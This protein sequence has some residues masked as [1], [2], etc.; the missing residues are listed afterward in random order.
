M[1]TNS[2]YKQIILRYSLHESDKLYYDK[3]NE[4]K[5]NDGFIVK[6]VDIF[7]NPSTFKIEMIDDFPLEC[8]IEYIERTHI[9]YTSKKLPEIEETLD[10]LLQQ[11]TS[12]QTIMTILSSFYAAYK[13]NLVTHILIAEKHLLPYIKYLQATIGYGFNYKVYLSKK[14]IYSLDDFKSDHKHSLEDDLVF[15]QKVIAQFYRNESNSTICEKFESLLESFKKDLQVHELIEDYILIPNAKIL[16][17]EL[18]Q[19]INKLARRN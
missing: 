15:I 9:Y 14:I 13:K 6:L 18:E 2:I 4:L 19:S 12:N 11:V 8:I 17:R 7:M 5:A 1:E 3:V 10:V 16:E